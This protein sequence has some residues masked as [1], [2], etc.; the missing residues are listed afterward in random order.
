MYGFNLFN[1]ILLRLFDV[2]NTTYLWANVEA[3]MCQRM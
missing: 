2:L 3:E 1:Q